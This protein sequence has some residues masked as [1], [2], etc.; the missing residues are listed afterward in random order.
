M[1]AIK[2]W[3]EWTVRAVVEPWAKGEADRIKCHKCHIS[4][5]IRTIGGRI[6]HGLAKSVRSEVSQR[7][8]QL[9]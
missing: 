9:S 2:W 7:K 5:S 8:E 3:A 4:T 6:E 1:L